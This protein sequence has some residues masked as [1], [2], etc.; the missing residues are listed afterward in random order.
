[1][2]SDDD[3]RKNVPESDGTEE[4]E[5]DGAMAGDFECVILDP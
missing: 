5:E 4:E 3:A 1:M 2:G